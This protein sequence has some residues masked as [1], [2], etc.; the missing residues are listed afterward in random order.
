VRTQSLQPGSAHG[1]PAGEGEGE[2][3][4]ASGLGLGLSPAHAA[5]QQQSFQGSCAL[6]QRAASCRLRRAMGRVLAHLI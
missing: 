3:K 5:R 4:V 1:L 2:M 6:A